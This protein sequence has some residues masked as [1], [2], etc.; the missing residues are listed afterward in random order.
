M[1]FYI[2]TIFTIALLSFTDFAQNGKNKT[3]EQVKPD[4]S[5]TWVLNDSKS[6][7]V[8]YDL[9]LTVVH[10]DPEMKV[11]KTYNLKGAKKIVEQIYYT[12]GRKMPD[13]AAGFSTISQEAYWQSGRLTHTQQASR[14]AGKTIQQTI[15][16][17]WELSIDGKTLT[18]TTSETASIP[19]KD[20]RTGQTATSQTDTTTILRFKRAEKSS[21]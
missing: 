13:T 20:M 19:S 2:F 15:T 3:D 9:T 6:N 10:R 8:G 11:T 4:F 21:E 18:L 7:N 14:D 1:K 16:E 5:G 12:D 17:K